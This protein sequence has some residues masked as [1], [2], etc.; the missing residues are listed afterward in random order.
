MRRYAPKSGTPSRTAVFAAA[1]IDGYMHHHL[2][3]VPLKDF[4]NPGQVFLG[5]VGSEKDYIATRVSS[6]CHSITTVVRR[7]LNLHDRYAIDGGGPSLNVNSACS[8]GLVAVAQAVRAL[9]S[10][11]CDMA[12]AGAAS[13]SFPNLGYMYVGPICRRWELAPYSCRVIFPGTAKGSSDH[14]ME[15]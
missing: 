6:V 4:G 1:G 12:V 14:V 5:E 8:S 7:L 10:G 3:G 15:R 9:Q 11:D 13:L 2:D